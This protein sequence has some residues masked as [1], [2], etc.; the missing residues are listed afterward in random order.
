MNTAEQKAALRRDMNARLLGVVGARW[1]QASLSICERVEGLDW[2]RDATG[3]MLYGSMPREVRLDSLGTLALSQGKRVVCPRVDFATR[4]MVAAAV[5]RWEDG[6]VT[7]RMGI[8]QPGEGAREAG[9][10]EISLVLVPGLAFDAGGGRLGR[11]GGFYDRFLAELPPE[12]RFLGVGI[13]E[14]VVV[15][16]P[17]SNWDVAVHAVAT[18]AGLRLI[19]DA[20]G[21]ATH[22]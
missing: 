1:E 3:V 14:Q 19:E 9:R 8:R 17:R 22:G 16:V 7:G 12:T 18:D 5:E 11:G 20:R 4:R 6:L 13:E 10:G 2:W 15:A 21:R